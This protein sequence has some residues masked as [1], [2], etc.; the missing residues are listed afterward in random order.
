M[1]VSRWDVDNKIEKKN[2][3]QSQSQAFEDNHA[4]ILALASFYDR[5]EYRYYIQDTSFYPLIP[6]LKNI[7]YCIFI[8]RRMD[9]NC[10]VR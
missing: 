2:V 6:V 8:Q 5:P 10:I 1:A 7:S 9:K 4:G 3:Q